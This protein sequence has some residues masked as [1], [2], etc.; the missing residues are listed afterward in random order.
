MISIHSHLFTW[1]TSSS[2]LYL[3][4]GKYNKDTIFLTAIVHKLVGTKK[5]RSSYFISTKTI[6]NQNIFGCFWLI[7]IVHMPFLSDFRSQKTNNFIAI[8]YQQD[9][10]RI[11]FSLSFFMVLI[12]LLSSM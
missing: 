11:V 3:S 1:P 5:Q 8:V 7:Y 9:I 10:R 6:M 4:T 2:I 12:D